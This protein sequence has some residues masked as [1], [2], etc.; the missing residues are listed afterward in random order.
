MKDKETIFKA[1]E[2]IKGSGPD[3]VLIPGGEGIP[4]KKAREM[5]IKID[6]VFIRRDGWTLGASWDLRA[7]AL[8][9]W[10][11]EFLAF[12]NWPELDP[13]EIEELHKKEKI[14]RRRLSF[15]CKDKKILEALWFHNCLNPGPVGLVLI[16]DRLT[17][18]RKVYIGQS[19][20][21]D[22]P[23][24]AKLIA[25]YG[26]PVKIDETI[27]FLLQARKVIRL[28]KGV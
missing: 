3:R 4:Y 10:S 6:V 23:T 15:N 8:K 25:N 21:Q 28:K 20:G 17:G 9:T 18:D 7:E 22:K 19:P 2:K 27:E 12:V 26:A 1:I 13:Q 5:E 11:D 16:E 14:S 24:D